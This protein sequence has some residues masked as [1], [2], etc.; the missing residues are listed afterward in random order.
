MQVAQTDKPS[1]GGRT[2]H[3][4]ATP[5]AVELIEIAAMAAADK[6][7]TDIIAYDVSEQLVISDAFLL[8]S[9]NISAQALRLL[10]SPGRADCFAP[11]P[12]GSPCFCAGVLMRVTVANFFLARISRAQRMEKQLVTDSWLLVSAEGFR[13]QQ[14]GRE[15]ALLVKELLQNSLDAAPATID[16]R[17]EYKQ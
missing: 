9:A 7:A 14:A 6:L 10:K 2:A 13:M 1:R 3:V 8:C 4:T 11:I 17:I 15:P 5:R 16:F 12:S